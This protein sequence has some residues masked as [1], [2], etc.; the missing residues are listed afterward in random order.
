MA[1][2]M[3][4]AEYEAKYGTPPQVPAKAP[5]KMTRAEY[6]AKYGALTGEKPSKSGFFGTIAD[7]AKGGLGKILEGTKMQDTQPSLAQSA[8]RGLKIAAGTT[9]VAT[10]P[11]APIFAPLGGIFKSVSDKLSETPTIKGAVGAVE[12][13]GLDGKP[14]YSPSPNQ[15]PTMAERV[16]DATGNASEVAGFVAGLKGVPTVRTIFTRPSKSVDD[17]IS[18]AD[19]ALTPNVPTTIRGKTPAEIRSNAEAAA[20]SMS[21]REKW[22]GLS[23]DIKKRIAGKQKQLQEYFDVA[24]ARNADDTVPTPYEYGSQRAQKAVDAMETNLNQTGGKIGQFRQKIGTYKATPDAVASIETSFNNQ[25]TRLN[26]EVRNGAIRQIPGTVTRIGSSSDIKVLT[27][28]F[29]DL[30]TVKQSPTLTNLI[31][32]RSAFDSRINFAK[33]AREAS[34]S[35]DPVSRQ[36]RKDIASTAAKLVGKS[37]ASQLQT[38]SDFMDAYNNLRSYTD[39]SAGGEY[40]LRLVMSGRGGEARAI[41]QTIKDYTGIDLMDDATMMTLATDFIGNERQKNLFRQE[42][43]KAGLDATALLKG[44]VR[45]LMGTIFQKAVDKAANPE[46]ILLDASR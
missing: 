14:K 23:P 34:N 11:L 22:I 4:R 7:A 5:V 18:Q 31:D 26:L 45:S 29:Q 41:V 35:I 13:V 2:Q 10:A 24:H 21:I 27:S 19:S 15:A 12:S 33:S 38:Y 25:L 44:D 9:E 28:L 40:L 20:P 3:T 8:E 17:V 43:T 1:V 42:V 37:E 46:K 32:L 39:R 16:L 6:E 30:Q 36:V